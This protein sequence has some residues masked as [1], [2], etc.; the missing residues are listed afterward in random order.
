MKDHMKNKQV[1]LVDRLVKCF[2]RAYEMERAYGVPEQRAFQAGVR[3]FNQE[4]DILLAA[5]PKQ[6]RT[7]I[8]DCRLAAKPIVEN[9]V[10]VLEAGDEK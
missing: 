6:E 9:W 7:F 1:E 3:A 5:S 2:I 8:L 10:R 4:F